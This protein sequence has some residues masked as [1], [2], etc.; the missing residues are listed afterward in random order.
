MLGM[1]LSRSSILEA[2]PGARRIATQT[3]DLKEGGGNY[4]VSKHQ[5]LCGITSLLRNFYLKINRRAINRS[6]FCHAG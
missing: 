4:F 1:G 5:T 6:S 3:E 2:Y